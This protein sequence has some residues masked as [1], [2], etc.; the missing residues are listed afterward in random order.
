[1]WRGRGAAIDAA[2]ADL[3]ANGD[4]RLLGQRR[5]AMTWAQRLKRVFGIDVSTC[6]H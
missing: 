5:R 1:M 4:H 2:P 6:A 3:K